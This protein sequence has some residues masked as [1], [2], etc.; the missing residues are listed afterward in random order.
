MIIDYNKIKNTNIDFFKKYYT[1]D[2]THHFAQQTGQHYK[3]L[4]YVSTLY[5]NITILDVG[6]YDGASCLALAQNKNNKVI[7]YDIENIFYPKISPLPF[8]NDYPNVSRKIMD[9]N[10]EDSEIIKSAQIIMLD[11]MHD[12]DT[13]KKFSDMLD[14][15]GYKGYVFCDDV[16]SNHHPRCSEWFSNLTVEKYDLTEIGGHNGTGLLNYYED[17]SVKIIKYD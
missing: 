13:E 9:I 3:L 8:I 12:G 5:D 7:T 11:I 6:T 15:I 10:T 1:F 2:E 16:F 4:S 17:K 14:S